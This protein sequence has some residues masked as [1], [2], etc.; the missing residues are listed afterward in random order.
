MESTQPEVRL[1]KVAVADVTLA[2]RE[3]GSPRG[4]PVVLVHALGSGAA[5]WAAFGARL[6]AHGRRV[7]A[8]DLRGHGGS[9]WTDAYSLTSMCDDVLAFLDAQGI[10]RTDLV[11]HSVGGAVAVLVAQ[12]QA[13]RVRRLVV[14]D[15]PPPPERAPEPLAPVTEPADPLPFEW[16]LIEP[17]IT[18]LRTPDPGWRERLKLISAATLLVGGGPASH[19]S[20][21]ALARVNAAVPDCRLVTVEDAG[22]RVHSVRPEEFWAVV[23]PFLCGTPAGEVT[24]P[25]E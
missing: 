22:H 6:A 11:G 1:G 8:L 13:D 3:V 18:E 20:P 12:R 15:T 23:A 24:R 5:T 7:L 10:G 2:F 21:D 14:E 25:R 4:V 17:I 19:V 9:S 16:R